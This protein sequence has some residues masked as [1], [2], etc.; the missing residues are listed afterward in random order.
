METSLARQLQRLKAPQTTVFKETKLR[1]SFLYDEKEAKSID[2]DM[3]YAIALS[4]LKALSSIYPAVDSFRETLFK[5]ES[6]TLER[7]LLTKEENQSLDEEIRRFL[8]EVLSPYLLITATHKMLEWLLLKYQINEYNGSDLILSALP[9]HETKLFPKIVQLVYEVKNSRSVWHWLKPIYKNGISLT[10]TVLINHCLADLGFL[11]LISEMIFQET[12]QKAALSVRVSFVTSILVNIME[13]SLSEEIVSII[14]QHLNN[15]WKSQNVSVIA[16]CYII[17]TLLAHKTNLNPKV[18]DKMLHR[19]SRYFKSAALK[20]KDEYMFTVFSISRSQKIESL[21]DKTIQS[22]D[23]GSL[24]RFS[25]NETKYLIGSSVIYLIKNLNDENNLNLL[26]AILNSLECSEEV[27]EKCL[28]T[29]IEVSLDNSVETHLLSSI[30]STL[31]RRFPSHFDKSISKVPYLEAKNLLVSSL[32]VKIGNTNSNV[33][34]ALIHPSKEVRLC[35]ISHLN[36]N[37]ENLREKGDNVRQ[38]LISS[39]LSI[40]DDMEPDILLKLLNCK[41]MLQKIFQHDELINCMKKLLQKIGK[42]SKEEKRENLDKLWD[43][44]VFAVIELLCG[45][46]FSD[47]EQFLNVFL[48]YIVPRNREVDI[49]IFEM[50]L[51]SKAAECSKL[52]SHLKSKIKSQV[53]FTEFIVSLCS[54]VATFC[55]S[56]RSSHFLDLL[57]ESQI[58]AHQIYALYILNSILMKSDEFVNYNRASLQIIILYR[59]LLKKKMLTKS[60][61]TVKT[62]EDIIKTNILHM[63]GDSVPEN[64][65]KFILRNIINTAIIPDV[66]PGWFW[67]SHSTQNC[68]LYSLFNFLCEFSFHKK[69]NVS[70]FF[71]KLLREFLDKFL[72]KIGTSFLSSLWAN[73]EN[74]TLQARSLLI[75]FKCLNKNCELNEIDTISLL[76]AL[77]SPSISIRLS[78]LKLVQKVCLKNVQI[79]ELIRSDIHAV[80]ASDSSISNIISSLT[81]EMQ[82]KSPQTEQAGSSEKHFIEQLIGIAID[83]STPVHIK[84]GLLLLL[85]QCNDEKTVKTFLPLLEQVLETHQLPVAKLIGVEIWT[86]I[87]KLLCSATITDF[88]MF[89]EMFFLVLKSKDYRKFCLGN[90]NKKWFASITSENVKL[91]IVEKLL[92]LIFEER[93][94]DIGK[95]LKKIINDGKLIV[96]LIENLTTNTMAKEISERKRRRTITRLELSIDQDSWKKVMI[97]LE[98]MQTKDKFENSTLLMKSLFALLKESFTVEE[99]PSLE[100]FRLLILSS[101]RLC[102]TQ[103]DCEYRFCDIHCILETFRH[104][105][106]RET[107]REALLLVSAL[108]PHYKTEILQNI[109]LV[110]GFIG[111]NLLH[112]DD[113]YTLKVMDETMNEII[114]LVVEGSEEVRD[115]VIEVFID[116]I[117]DIAAHRR[118]HLFRKLSAL[119]DNERLLWFIVFKL[120]ERIVSMNDDDRRDFLDFSRIFVCSYE[121]EIQLSTFVKLLQVAHYLDNGAET[122]FNRKVFYRSQNRQDIVNALVINLSNILSAEELS[123]K[124]LENDWSMNQAMFKKLIE[125]SLLFI[126]KVTKN[127]SGERSLNYTKT[128]S[129]NLYKI[130]EKSSHLTSFITPLCEVA[131]LTN[132]K[133]EQ[134][135]I[136]AQINVVVLSCVTALAKLTRHF[137]Q[138][139]GSKLSKILTLSCL[140]KSEQDNET[141]FESKFKTMAKNISTLIPLRTLVEALFEAYE[142]LSTKSEDPIVNLLSIFCDS[143]ANVERTDLEAVLPEVQKLIFK[144]LDY[145]NLNAKEKPI[146]SID[147][148]EDKTIECVVTFVPKLSELT[149]HRLKSLFCVFAAPYIVNNCIIQLEKLNGENKENELTNHLILTNVMMTLSKCFLHDNGT[150]ATHER[151]ES[152]IAPIINQLSNTLGTAEMQDYRADECIAACVQN[153]VRSV[154]DTISVK[155]IHYKILLKTRE[156]SEKIRLNALKVYHQLVLTMKGDYLPLLPEAVTFLAELHEDDSQDIQKLLIT[157]FSDIEEIVGEPITEYF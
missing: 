118:L 32:Y 122:I 45:V 72:M 24:A 97:L 73:I 46:D 34:S 135:A 47:E 26:T 86:K 11:K 36:D 101:I 78:A 39:I 80:E 145:R 117:R 134:L 7:G 48:P 30:L 75:G 125:I 16:S 102:L 152:L 71:R 104:A 83:S 129:R 35:A 133:N 124:I 62:F 147:A 136:N 23:F 141:M 22:F 54:E 105:R 143:L 131:S 61:E 155:D 96:D 5:E 50:I 85:K 69:P 113:E 99:K 148:I 58:A 40:I 128:L 114:P 3:H 94:Q 110:F 68:Y 28:R 64:I 132:A 33:T 70:S 119:L 89:I 37:V 52:F 81:T 57:Y 55:L 95:K 150:F 154:D 130:L 2:N 140:A 91:T 93:D 53:E 137:G 21:P 27:V 63:C 108:A 65:P 56:D 67:H 87:S 82:S 66:K 109:M 106:Q 59:K 127:T 19:M 49:K 126:E 77:T 139:L 4:G 13:R 31:E 74:P 15:G 103:S 115:N 12:T 100:Y 8:F 51:K 123:A 88:D 98:V 76:I 6:K 92:T 84:Y 149:F 153:L 25:P 14:I 112:C 43:D 142:E 138:F 9:Y 38:S 17:F 156:N 10:K 107:Q 116:S 144:A 44:V 41:L 90:M 157:V 42:E 20:L 121:P 151:V 18:L 79:A 60:S 120:T 29:I 111:S 146:A 1:A